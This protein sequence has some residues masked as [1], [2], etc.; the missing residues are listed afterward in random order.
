MRG[1]CLSRRERPPIPL[2]AY[3]SVAGRCPSTSREEGPQ[4]E[5]SLL[6]PWPWAFQPPQLWGVNVCCLGPWFMVFCYSSSNWLRQ[7]LKSP[8]SWQVTCSWPG[9]VLFQDLVH[10][11]SQLSAPEVSHQAS[12]YQCLLIW[13]QVIQDSS[14]NALGF[15]I[16]GWLFLIEVQLIYNVVLISAIQQSD[17]VYTYIYILF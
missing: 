14:R 13:M 6:A 2:S 3:D 5:L 17:S 1:W 10:L 4:R 12:E 7:G 11:L 9:R 16:V 15:F 8:Q